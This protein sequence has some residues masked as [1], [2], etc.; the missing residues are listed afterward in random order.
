MRAAPG[1]VGR[2]RELAVLLGI[3]E[4]GGPAVVH[5]HG[6]AGVG[7][8]AL[9]E[10]FAHRARAAGAT[11]VALDGRTIEPT[12]RGFLTELSAAIGGRGAPVD[13]VAARLARLGRTVVLLVDTYEVLRLVDSWLWRVFVP[14]LSPNVRL[15]VAGRE[16]PPPARVSR[17]SRAAVG[18]VVPVGA[19]DPGAAV[20]LLR[21]LE[22][23]VDAARRINR[24]ARGH[25][26][27]L[28]LGALALRE[29]APFEIED[30]AIVRVL[31]TLTETWLADVRDPLT[32]QVL[33]AASVVRVVTVPLLRAMLPGAAPQDAFDRL[34]A[35]PLAQM[36]R[37]GLNV[38]DAVKHAV[39]E[40]F[41]AADPSRY[42]A[43][44]RAA[45]RHLLAE[46]RTAG[47]PEFW[48]Y[49]ADILYLL[50]NPLVREAFFPSDA[51]EQHVVEPAR[52]GDGDAIL[53]IVERHEGARGARAL[54]AWWRR[55]PS[56]FH[57]VRGADGGVRGFYCMAEAGAVGPLLRRDDPVLAQ[58]MTYLASAP[59][60]RDERVLLCRRWLAD[61]EGE[62]ASSPRAA[63]WL[64]IKRTYMEL[65]P[66]LRRIVVTLT[67]PGPV[68][69]FFNRL[70]F[71]LLP[72]HAV[73]L[74]G[75]RYHSAVLDFGPQ[76]VD[77]WLAGI[78]ASEL[79][80]DPPLRLDQAT[81]EVL[82]AG[83]RVRLAPR[84]F[85]VFRRLW[86]EPGITV[87]RDALLHDAWERYDGDSNVV[88]VTIRSLRRKL[89]DLGATVETVR[90]AG[91][92]VRDPAP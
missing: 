33:D 9:L 64:D 4:P 38:H 32:R 54:A 15:V 19:L 56:A 86:Q 65:R 92:R 76:S 22:V 11:V 82:A 17:R 39:A 53:R 83:A 47:R 87:S 73:P 61:E 78:V 46:S 44:R 55:R 28:T 81:R 84:E 30:T 23:T 40:L 26:L 52:A 34:R 62:A 6:I 71:R 49:T 36:S 72:E 35:L 3:L 69:A 25:P 51:A 80:V 41:R 2:D 63:T 79:G 42:R 60:A 90:G 89:V 77:G 14:A 12:P 85:A 13:R 21:G 91:Y 75:R 43:Y 7:K 24:F 48:R 31:A 16:P 29:R 45:W 5:V 68:E 37:E 70:G 59:V 67:D 18:A 50:E 1:L 27:A 20:A 8:S 10:A 57:V 74:D 58:V 88:D 66:H